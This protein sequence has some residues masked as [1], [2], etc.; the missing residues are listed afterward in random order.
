MSN[1][2]TIGIRAERNTFCKL[3]LKS[4]GKLPIGVNIL[5][6]PTMPFTREESRLVEN[7]IG[8]EKRTTENMPI[9]K[10][11]LGAIMH[12]VHTGSMLSYEASVDGYMVCMKR[13]IQFATEIDL[14]REFCAADQR[15]LLLSNTD[16][17]VNIRSAR[18]LRPGHNLHDQMSVIFG[19]G[20]DS[21]P[22]ESFD[23]GKKTVQK[24]LEYKQVYSSPWASGEDQERMFFSMMNN[25][26]SLKMDQKTTALMAM[27]ALF[28]K[29]TDN[30]KK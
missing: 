21:L 30:R 22:L 7:V 17:L 3:L 1:S 24:R 15:N 14:F 25:I 16:M 27:M 13:I 11:T 5:N 10:D 2:K 23:Q 28:S 8:I 18:M 12:A 26:F 19:R 20:T 29:V 9:S 4:K 6:E